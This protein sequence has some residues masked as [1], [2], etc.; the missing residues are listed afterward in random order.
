[1]RIMTHNRVFLSETGTLGMPFSEALSLG[2][3]TSVTNIF[4]EYHGLDGE[5]RE[6]YSQSR[7][8]E[9]IRLVAEAFGVSVEEIVSCSKRRVISRP[10]HVAMYILREDFWW[11]F[12]SLAI[13]FKKNCH[14][15]ILYA[16]SGIREEMKYD[17]SLCR[18]IQS[19][20]YR[21]KNV[22]ENT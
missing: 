15:T 5:H 12:E 9:V 8:E 18:S 3:S 21:L 16:H 11:T 22:V 13:V 1:M 17:A 19:I 10:R 4:S 6:T 7:A 2:V 20:R 14:G